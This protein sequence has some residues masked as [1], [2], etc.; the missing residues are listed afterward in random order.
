MSNNNVFLIYQLKADGTL[1]DYRFEPF[2]CLQNKGLSVCWQNYNHIYTGIF[3]GDVQ[4]DSIFTKFNINRPVD[5]VGHSLSVS[6]VIVLHCGEDASAHYVDNAGFVDVPEFLSE[7]YKYYSIQRP[8]DV[9]T[10]PKMESGPVRIINF[11]K[12]T[13]QENATFQAWGYLTYNAPLTK[14]HLT[15]YE[16]RAASDN[17]NQVKISPYQLEAQVQVV[18]KWEKARCISDMKRFTWWHSD[19]G[20]FVKKEFVTDDQLT[21]RFRQ[22]MDAGRSD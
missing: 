12:R 17:P 10:F 22:A 16:L 1:R 20:V 8:A 9:G 18:G 13:R 5:F 3:E 11:D 7:P 15:E 19:F 6:D 21:E 4:L 2:D 14:E